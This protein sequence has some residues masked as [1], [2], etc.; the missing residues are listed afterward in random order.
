M[1]P[2]SKPLS[3][4]FDTSKNI[5]PST[6]KMTL[7]EIFLDKTLKGKDKVLTIAEGLTQHDWEVHDLLDCAETLK[8]SEKATCIE[9]IECVTRT[10]P[11]IA[12][13]RVF[14]FV[15]RS[16]ND[17]EPRVKWESAKVIGN[18]AKLFPSQLGVAIP[19]LLQNAQNKGTVVRWAAAFALS[20]ILILNTAHNQD[21]LPQ[22]E[23]LFEREE[24]NGVKKKYAAALKK[25]LLKQGK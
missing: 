10:N 13:E 25:V 20:E 9:A 17:L 22:I 23:L 2:Q 8:A 15:I 19:N 14:E 5:Y 1:Y 16:L 24:N 12:T 7:T 21:L 6:A 18:V 11:A 3:I 4:P